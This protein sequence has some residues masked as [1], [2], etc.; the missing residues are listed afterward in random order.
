MTSRDDKL[1][2]LK[3]ESYYYCIKHQH[4]TEKCNPLNL[5]VAQFCLLRNDKGGH[6]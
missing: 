6:R 5:A 2:N 1:S 4:N 3:M